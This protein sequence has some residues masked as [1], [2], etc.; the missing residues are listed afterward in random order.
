MTRRYTVD[1]DRVV[2]A[3]RR[4]VMK[5]DETISQRAD[6]PEG[7][8]FTTTRY[9]YDAQP[10]PWRIADES[11][12]DGAV[13][14]VVDTFVPNRAITYGLVYDH[15]GR[16][17]FLNDT[18]TMQHL[19]QRLDIDLDP[20]A[21]AELLA[22]LYSGDQVTSAVVTPYSATAFY[23]AGELVTNVAAFVNQYPAVDASLVSAPVVRRSGGST[24]VE[25]CSCHYSVSGMIG[26]LDILSW[27]VTGGSGQEVSWSRRYLAKHLEQGF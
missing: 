9:G 8:M 14:V 26:A 16:E 17:L 11:W 20:I 25:F 3:M 18:R 21:Y 5:P 24:V 19:G 10:A 7:L 1:G 2:D 23:P 12:V 4:L 6:L 27:S 13:R 22:E 15:A